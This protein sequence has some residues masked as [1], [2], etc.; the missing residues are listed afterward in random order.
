MYW[1]IAETAGD[2]PRCSY[3]RICSDGRFLDDEIILTKAVSQSSVWCVDRAVAGDRLIAIGDYLQQTAR[4]DD[5]AVGDLYNIGEVLLRFLLSIEQ[6]REQDPGSLA[7]CRIKTY[8]SKV[9]AREV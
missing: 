7:I 2:R 3:P 9:S 4:P 1:I 6:R 8:I 5:C